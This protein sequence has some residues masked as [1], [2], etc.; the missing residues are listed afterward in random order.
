MIAQDKH[1]AVAA[2]GGVEGLAPTATLRFQEG[3]DI[4]F[5]WRE[6]LQHHLPSSGVFCSAL[7]T[8][9]V[10]PVAIRYGIY[11]CP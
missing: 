4:L 5:R 11:L 10:I 2:F 8:G 3:R 9:S 7:C 1:G 6:C